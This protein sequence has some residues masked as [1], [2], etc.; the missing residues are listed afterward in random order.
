MSDATPNAEHFDVFPCH[1]SEDKTEIRQ[2][3]DELSRRGLKP[4]LDEQ[5]IP[6]GKL[7]Q[8]KRDRVLP[9]YNGTTAGQIRLGC[10]TSRENIAAS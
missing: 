2:V 5:E 7:W 9:S 6:P 3:A 4:W 8:E 1:N 10:M